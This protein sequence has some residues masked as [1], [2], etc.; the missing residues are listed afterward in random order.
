MTVDTY[1]SEIKSFRDFIFTSK[2]DYQSWCEVTLDDARDFFRELSSNGKKKR[3]IN[4]YITSLRL[5][6]DYLIVLCE[7]QENP[8]RHI[9]FYK[10]MCEAPIIL[11][12][13][14]SARLVGAPMREYQVLIETLDGPKP[15]WHGKLIY[16]RDQ[17][18]LEMLYYS[19][20][21][22]SEL[23]NL[24][25][26]D[27]DCEEM[28]VTISGKRGRKKSRILQLPECVILTFK[29]YILQR[30]KK[31]LNLTW[32]ERPIVLLNRS[33]GPISARSVRR[34]I[35]AYAQKSGLHPGISPETLRAT[36]TLKA[37]RNRADITT[38]QYLL[39]FEDMTS[40]ESY[41]SRFKS[42]LQKTRLNK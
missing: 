14:K 1:L 34:K 9:D 16:L 30:N 37:I 13:K 6:Y 35:A 5:F 18:I 3:T 24:R 23:I 41:V 28:V 15:R 31:W 38:I 22:V 10:I 33:G 26:P 17:L 20:M 29:D 40:A 39:G 19:G 11:D 42:V 7:A 36:F 27:I 25:D 4:R 2:R 12:A 8:F 21:K 32:E